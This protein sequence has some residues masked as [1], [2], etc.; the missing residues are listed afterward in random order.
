LL[1]SLLT[2]IEWILVRKLR[3][4]FAVAGGGESIALEGGRV[5][6]A[7]SGDDEGPFSA[8]GEYRNFCP[9]ALV[10]GVI[11]PYYQ[12]MTSTHE[13]STHLGPIPRRIWG[14]S[15][16]PKRGSETRYKTSFQ[17]LDISSPTSTPTPSS[18][19]SMSRRRSV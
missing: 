4:V 17:R 5:A 14:S 15:R 16:K 10:R 3:W 7:D 12:L 8:F 9:A 13:H 18:Q 1:T 2:I 19:T 6:R 11:V